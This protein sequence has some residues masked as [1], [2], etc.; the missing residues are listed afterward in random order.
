MTDSKNFFGN[1]HFNKKDDRK[2]NNSNNSDSLSNNPNSNLKNTENNASSNFRKETNQ[3]SEQKTN[4]E[5]L[6]QQPKEF[7][8]RIDSQEDRKKL[9]DIIKSLRKNIEIKP[10]N[11]QQRNLDREEGGLEQ[12]ISKTEIKIIDEWDDRGQE[13]EE[14]GKHNPLGNSA[15]KSMIWNLKRKRLQEKKIKEELQD[16]SDNLEKMKSQNKQRNDHSYSRKEKSLVQRI[17]EL[18]KNRADSSKIR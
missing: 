11:N 13:I 2:N 17:Q 1:N 5:E 7:K 18:H 12:E 9:D 6:N 14:M 8:E 3:A 10:L 4:F 15:K 16:L